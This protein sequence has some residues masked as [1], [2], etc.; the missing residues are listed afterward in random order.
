MIFSPEGIVITGDLH[1]GRHERANG[2]ISRGYD[3][4]WFKRELSTTYLAEKFLSRVWVPESFKEYVEEYIRDGNLDN[5]PKPWR[6][7]HYE[8]DNWTEEKALKYLIGHSDLINNP[9]DTYDNLPEVKQENN[10]W[11]C[12]YDG[13]FAGTG[14]DYD[15]IETGWLA[16]IQQRFRELYK[17]QR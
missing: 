1:P 2:V 8:E 9:Y 7:G 17:Q 6:V 5:D 12:P 16:A 3:L 4:D 10:T 13:D 14:Y 11:L 15:P